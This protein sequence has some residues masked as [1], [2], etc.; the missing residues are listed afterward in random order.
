MI[1]DQ[2]DLNAL[3]AQTIP[4]SQA[5][6]FSGEGKDT[7]AQIQ[8]MLMVTNLYVA[9]IFGVLARVICSAKHPNAVIYANRAWSELTSY[10]QHEIAGKD[11][12]LLQG[13]W[14]NKENIKQ[15]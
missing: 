13:P 14:T 10:D 4:L 3:K 5:L 1:Y 11:L 12:T 9:P 6:A 15:V 8:L 2:Q 7:I